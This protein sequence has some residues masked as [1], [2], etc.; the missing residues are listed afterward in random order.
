MVGRE[1]RQPRVLR[2]LRCCCPCRCCR[3]FSHYRL[4]LPP[5]LCRGQQRCA[6][7]H[8]HARTDDDDDYEWSGERHS[9]AHTPPLHARVSSHNLPVDGLAA[10]CCER[11]VGFAKVPAA[12][13]ASMCRQTRGV[14]RLEDGAQP[15]LARAPRSTPRA[16]SCA[17]LPHSR[18]TSGGGGGGGGGAAAPAALD[19][20][21][22]TCATS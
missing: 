9:H 15:R 20:P 2:L 4:L 14:R 10:G 13:E 3:R 7:A 11:V 6:P 16:F 22:A 21:R 1:V 18:K 12:K 8:V 17:C 19:P 5:L